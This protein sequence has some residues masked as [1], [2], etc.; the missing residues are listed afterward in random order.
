MRNSLICRRAL[1]GRLCS[2]KVFQ[3]MPISCAT[4]AVSGGGIKARSVFKVKER[5]VFHHVPYSYCRDP[6]LQARQKRRVCAG[7]PCSR[8]LGLATSYIRGK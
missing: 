7:S 8:G 6:L 1:A 3:L 4:Q 2:N 5:N